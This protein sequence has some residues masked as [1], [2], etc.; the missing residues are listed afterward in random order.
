MEDGVAE[1]ADL[2]VPEGEGVL[3][4]CLLE[5]GTQVLVPVET[6]LHYN[7]HQLRLEVVQGRGTQVQKGF[8]LG[9]Q[10]GREGLKSHV[11]DQSFKLLTIRESFR[12]GLKLHGILSSFRPNRYLGDP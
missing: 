2:S 11:I 4:H 5:D 3:R 8:R 12:A 10:V 9:R 1:V 7:V 6:P